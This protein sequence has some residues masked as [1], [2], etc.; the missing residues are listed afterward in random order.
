MVDRATPC[1]GG[2]RLPFKQC[3]V[4]IEGD[5]TPPLL[6]CR[7][8]SKR[9]HI[10]LN[11]TWDAARLDSPS[12]LFDTIGRIPGNHA[13]AEQLVAPYVEMMLNRCMNASPL[14]LQRI[15]RERLPRA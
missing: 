2:S 8:N 11:V 12:L 5:V 4:S 10:P 3:N 14:N 15:V 6:G 13:A 1:F 7:P 9:N